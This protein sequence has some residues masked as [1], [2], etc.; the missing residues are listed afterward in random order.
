MYFAIYR[1]FAIIELRVYEFSRWSFQTHRVQRANMMLGKSS[2]TCFNI[3][4]S[5]FVT[6][7]LH[8]VSHILLA[9]LD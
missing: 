3:S 8:I 2:H 9:H 7:R 6:D 1:K 4:Q 5:Y